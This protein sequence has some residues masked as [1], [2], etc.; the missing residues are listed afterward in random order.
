[1]EFARD[2]ARQFHRTFPSRNKIFHEPETVTSIFLMLEANHLGE[3]PRIASLTNPS[4]KMS[5]TDPDKNSKILLTTPAAEIRKR[6]SRALTDNVTE[7]YASSE[8]PGVTNLLT[9]LA[10]F[11]RCGQNNLEEDVRK[12]SM[13]AFKERVSEAIVK[14][15]GPIQAR[16]AEVNNDKDWLERV[17]KNGNERAR[18]VASERMSLI[19][20]TIGLL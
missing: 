16:F 6:I 15:L 2:L 10:A 13:K 12:L 20:E 1:L 7:I 14:A 17:R 9:I 19:K 4:K 18:Q 11:E 3:Y 8:R 5:K